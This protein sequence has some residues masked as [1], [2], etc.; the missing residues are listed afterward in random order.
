MHFAPFSWHFLFI[1]PKP[2]LNTLFS[3]I[4]IC[5]SFKWGTKFHT[6]TE[7]ST[8]L[9][10]PHTSSLGNIRNCLFSVTV[11]KVKQFSRAPL[12]LGA[13]S[14]VADDVPRCLYWACNSDVCVLCPV[15][16][17]LNWSTHIIRVSDRYIK[18]RWLEIVCVLL[19]R[20]MHILL[21][22]CLCLWPSR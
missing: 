2:M 14:G 19:S 10:T 9:Y 16:A 8:Y 13:V 1:R 17:S 6:R 11:K 12:L 21:F 3:N 7:R 18:V 5:S 20:D 22:L 4:N 15:Q